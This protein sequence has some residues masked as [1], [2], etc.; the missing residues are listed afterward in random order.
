MRV[1][2]F[3]QLRV[4]RPGGRGQT[5]EV[6]LWTQTNV[7]EETA[8]IFVEM[9]EGA[10]LE[11]EDADVLLAQEWPR[12]KV[13]EKRRKTREGFGTGMLHGLHS[14]SNTEAVIR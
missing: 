5:I 8:W 11:V 14:C 2:S 9:Q 6:S 12:P 7:R 13:L 1:D 3:E 4:V 10:R